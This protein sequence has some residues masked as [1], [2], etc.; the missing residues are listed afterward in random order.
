MIQIDLPKL[1]KPFPRFFSRH[2]LIKAFLRIALESASQLVSIINHAHAWVAL[3]DLW[4]PAAPE[5]YPEHY[6]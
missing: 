3:G 4:G 2:P 6:C 1:A 5:T